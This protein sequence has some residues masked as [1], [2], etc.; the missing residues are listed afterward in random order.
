MLP[1]AHQQNDKIEGY[2]LTIEEGGQMLLA[3]SGLPM[4]FWG[5]AVLTSQYLRNRLPTSTL[6][7]NI[8]LFEAL[9]HQKPDL[10]HLHV[11]GCQCFVTIPPE[12][13]T[14][15]GPRRFEVIFVGYEEARIGWTIR[16][17]KG[18]VHFLRDVI[19]NEDLSGRLGIPCSPSVRVPDQ[20]SPLIPICSI[21]DCIRT[22]AG[23]DYDEALH[24]QNKHSLARAGGRP[25]KSTV[26]TMV[27]ATDGGASTI[28]G[29]A[30][31]ALLVV[32]GAMMDDWHLSE[33]LLGDFI[34][35]VASSQ[36]PDP[37]DT[38]SLTLD[39]QEILWNHS[40]LSFPDSSPSILLDPVC[41]LSENHPHFVSKSL[42][43]S[44]EPRIFSDAM[45]CPDADAWQATMDREKMSLKKMG[46]LEE[47]DLPKGE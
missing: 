6:P 33:D 13:H 41:L 47:V 28:P 42:D 2:V 35:Y 40:L 21:G 24:L 12:L 5:W 1:Y 16:N 36:L 30:L 45:A 26:T 39:E 37:V 8:T 18:K 15:A 10:S 27:V 32:G 44:K 29:S 9:S 31:L 46:A 43:L 11:W 22:I 23:R 17:L 34:S 19:F 14:K 3:D 25:S 7:T 4:T 20:D 38:F